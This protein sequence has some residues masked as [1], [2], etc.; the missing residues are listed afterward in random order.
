VADSKK[1]TRYVYGFHPV[2]EALR[3]GN[4]HFRAVYLRKG[5]SG[6]RARRLEELARE[7]GLK[8]RLVDHSALDRLAMGNAHQGV[9]AEVETT[10]IRD[11]ESFLAGVKGRTAITIVVSDGIKD[12][13]NLGAIIRNC[14]LSGAAALILPKDRNVGI[15]PVVEKVA[16][17]GLEYV[18]IVRVG[19]VSGAL[20]RIKEETFW[21]VGADPEGGQALPAFDFR[22]RVAIVVGEEHRGLRRLTREHCDQ[23]VRI[24]STGRVASYNVGVAAGIILFWAFL[25]REEER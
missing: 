8:V 22:R 7:S 4:R 25:Q 14:S 12:P 18:D 20:R 3:A 21:V 19:N 16:A 15:T 17:G 1:V 2:E 10:G 5:K 11:L 6:H 23:L 9:V 13:H 24:P